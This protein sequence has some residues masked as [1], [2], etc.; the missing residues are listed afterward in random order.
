MFPLEDFKKE[1][2]ISLAEG[3]ICLGF[4][5]DSLCSDIFYVHFFDGLHVN[6]Q[7]VGKLR[8]GLLDLRKEKINMDKSRT[9]IHFLFCLV[10]STFISGKCDVFV[11]LP[12]F[13][14][15]N[16]INVSLDF[17]SFES[18]RFSHQ[19]SQIVNVVFFFF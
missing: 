18:N 17:A 8:I 12:V 16:H 2:R 1:K 6:F 5:S 3:A 10:V 15:L 14:L 11:P 13:I 4:L 19:V 9:L 7:R